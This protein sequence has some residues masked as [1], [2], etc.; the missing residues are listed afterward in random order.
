M[1]AAGGM[2]ALDIW[3]LPPV[4]TSLTLIMGKQKQSKQQNKMWD[5]LHHCTW[6][7]LY[8]SFSN[9]HHNHLAALLSFLSP[10]K[11]LSPAELNLTKVS[12]TER[13]FCSHQQSQPPYCRAK[14]SFTSRVPP[15]RERE[16]QSRRSRRC[17][18]SLLI[19]PLE[20][21]ESPKIRKGA[22]GDQKN[23]GRGIECIGE[24]LPTSSF[25]HTNH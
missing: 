25:W 12:T 21:E 11:L 3:L 24:S 1:L 20:V 17:P 9:H 23:Q 4:A 7:M 16:L 15:G 13:Y 14:S 2:V 18:Y 10:K 5:M 22:G 6:Q 19:S 8:L